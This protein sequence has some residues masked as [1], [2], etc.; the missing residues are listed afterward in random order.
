[1][2]PKHLNYYISLDKYLTHKVFFFLEALNSYRKLN[3]KLPASIII[4]K[5]VKDCSSIL[6]C[7]IELKVIPIFNNKWLC[8]IDNKFHVNI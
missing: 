7:E 5:V 2:L 8:I 3:Q 6:F 4:Y 1:M